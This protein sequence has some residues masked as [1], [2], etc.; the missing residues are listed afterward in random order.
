MPVYNYCITSN[1]VHV[2]AHVEDADAVASMMQLASAT[3]ARRW[4]RRKGHEGSVWEHPYR[5]TKVQDGRHLLRCLRYVS[6]NMVRAGVVDHPA[7]WRWCGH[8]ELT[9]R[10]LRYRIL[11]LDRLLGS[12]EMPSVESMREIYRSG[13]DE[14]IARREM[15]RDAAWT[16]A[17]A[18]GDRLFVE[19]AVA[20]M[21]NRSRFEYQPACG[22]DAW[23]VHE[24]PETYSSFST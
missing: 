19:R 21:R 18:V 8:D 11:S 24:S 6:L 5:C 2:I 22:G 14:M 17:L 9:G 12:L 7:E 1:H 13:V 15:E 16:D 4:N 3:V 10:R 23:T 20:Q